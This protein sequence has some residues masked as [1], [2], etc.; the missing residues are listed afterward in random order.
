MA[1]T[2]DYFSELHASKESQFFGTPHGV[3]DTDEAAALRARLEEAPDDYDL[4]LELASK[5]SFQ[6]RYREALELCDRAVALRPDGLEALRL[7]AARRL[8]TLQTKLAH[9]DYA[10]AFS[11]KPDAT[12]VAYRLGIS[13]YILRRYK[14]AEELFGM[15]A[16]RSVE[17]PEALVAAY[18]WLALTE[19]RTHSG[20]EG[21]RGFDFSSDI[22]HHT[23]YRDGLLVLCGR[24]SAEE[25]YAAVSGAED[26]LNGCITLYAAAARCRLDGNTELERKIMSEILGWDDFWPGFAYLAAWSEK[27]GYA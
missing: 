7:R 27:E 15:C 16:E 20:N 22:D 12:E 14:E 21:W 2:H 8:T 10:A 9:E 3:S 5:L 18:Y 19:A 25:M 24:V 23:G 1:H 11:L 13:A 26:S 6:L 17:E 4:L